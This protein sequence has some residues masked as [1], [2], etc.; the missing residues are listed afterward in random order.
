MN[1]IQRKLPELGNRAAREK[2]GEWRATQTNIGHFVMF[3]RI[4]QQRRQVR[5]SPAE[6]NK[7]HQFELLEA[8][9]P[10]TI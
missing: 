3:H 8:W 5:L 4:L 1:I 2:D 9:E 7:L 10:P 6:C